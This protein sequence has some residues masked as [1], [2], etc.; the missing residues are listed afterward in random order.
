MTW[1]CENIYVDYKRL[2]LGSLS[3]LVFETRTVTESELFSPLKCIWH[4]KYFLLIWK[5]LQNTEE[6]RFSFWNILFRF[7]GID[8]FPL[9]KLISD[10]V[11]LFAT[12]NGKMLN[13]RYLWKYWSSV[14]ETWH[15]NCASQKKQNYAFNGVAIATLSAPVSFCPKSK[16]PVC[17][18][19]NDTRGAILNRH[20][21]HIVLTPINRS[22]G[23]DGSWFKTK[24]GNFSFYQDST[25]SQTVAMAIALRV[26]LYFFCDAPLWCQVSRTLLQYF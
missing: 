6:W 24:T 12:K 1:S 5:A 21:S 17:N 18:P 14:L 15:H 13:R 11:I 10:G 23:V 9:C 25:S 3:T 19:W 2:L 16:Y 22:C 26:S 8:V 20:S 7:R 4:E